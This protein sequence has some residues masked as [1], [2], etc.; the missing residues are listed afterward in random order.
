VEI[1]D[2][3]NIEKLIKPSASQEMGLFSWNNPRIELEFYLDSKNIEFKQRFM[4]DFEKDE[5]KFSYRHVLHDE[6]D[7]KNIF[8]LIIT[9]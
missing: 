3:T 9:I 2:G 5:H 8:F 4:I 1:N 6:K 7:K